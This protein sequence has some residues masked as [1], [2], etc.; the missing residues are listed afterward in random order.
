M[1]ITLLVIVSHP[2]FKWTKCSAKLRSTLG[3]IVKDLSGTDMDA[4]PNSEAT[5]VIKQLHNLVMRKHRGRQTV[6]WLIQ[7]EEDYLQT[8][9]FYFNEVPKTSSDHDRKYRSQKIF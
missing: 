8:Q 9:R 6:A 1:W 4:S 3:A 2:L 5:A 7:N